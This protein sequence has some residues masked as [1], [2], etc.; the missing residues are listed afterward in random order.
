[1]GN[2][3]SNLERF[4]KNGIIKQSEVDGALEILQETALKDED[5]SDITDWRQGVEEL[6][7]IRGA[8]K[9]LD[10]AY[11]EKQAQRVR[12]KVSSG[13]THYKQFNFKETINKRY[14]VRRKADRKRRKILHILVFPFIG[15]DM[16]TIRDWRECYCVCKAWR[17]L[18]TDD[19][20]WR[21]RLV[22]LQPRP[23]HLSKRMFN[24]DEY[25][26]YADNNDLEIEGGHKSD[27]YIWSPLSYRKLACTKLALMVCDADK[28]DIFEWPWDK[29]IMSIHCLHLVA[30]L[31]NYDPN[32]KCSILGEHFDTIAFG[33]GGYRQQSHILNI[34][35]ISGVIEFP[36]L[37]SLLDVYYNREKEGS[38]TN[39]MDIKD[40][41]R[42]EECVNHLSIFERHPT[43]HHHEDDYH[44]GRTYKYEL[45]PMIKVLGETKAFNEIY[46]LVKTIDEYTSA[47]SQEKTFQSPRTRYDDAPMVS[48]ISFSFELLSQIMK[49]F[50]CRN[51]WIKLTWFGENAALSSSFGIGHH[52]HH[53][54][55]ES[56][57]DIFRLTM[58]EKMKV[59]KHLRALP[60]LRKMHDSLDSSQAQFAYLQDVF[61]LTNQHGEIF[62]AIHVKSA[63]VFLPRTKTTTIRSKQLRTEMEEEEKW[64]KSIEKTSLWNKF[65]Q[66]ESQSIRLGSNTRSNITS[67][68]FHSIVMETTK[69]E[70]SGITSGNRPVSR[71]LIDDRWHDANILAFAHGYLVKNY[72]GETGVLKISSLHLTYRIKYDKN[73]EV[74][75]EEGE[76]EEEEEEDAIVDAIEDALAHTNIAVVD[77]DEKAG[78]FQTLMTGKIL[79]YR[80]E[81]HKVEEGSKT[82]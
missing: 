57:G 60:S 32:L 50:V 17:N 31:T 16:T 37:K 56:A 49:S 65:I 18:L 20:L 15:R 27:K 72:R 12:K 82:I 76:N 63:N 14:S 61:A 54:G 39:A 19:N 10:I 44:S 46:L 28:D 45:L 4:V 41:E 24:L 26:S 36:N 9:I 59:Q 25:H 74:K 7:A 47:A 43:H 6:K 68:L 67:Q 33:K 55:K 42:L 69:Y 29:E 8:I 81:H 3:V 22:Y 52:G 78:H 23:L 38:K 71:K 35:I 48:R 51:Q 62:F 1:M 40:F 11:D 64:A 70:I 73:I 77:D 2:G 79:N 66:N 75:H 21:R 53:I 30:I 58:K 5:A 80:L 13:S 34:S